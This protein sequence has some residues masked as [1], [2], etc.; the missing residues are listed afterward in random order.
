MQSG[1]SVN[2][3]NKI[4][5]AALLCSLASYSAAQV[6][7]EDAWVQLA[8]PAITVNAVYMQIHNPQLRPQTIVSLSADCCAMVM[9]H[10]TRKMGDKVVMEHLDYLE[11]PAQSKAQLA[12]GGMHIMLMEPQEELTLESKVKLTFSF[13]DGSTQEFDLHVKN[14]DL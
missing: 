5:A 3:Y 12:P 6:L 9:L 4:G 1:V 13:S 14:N 10:N 11:L 8:P 2:Y 7:I